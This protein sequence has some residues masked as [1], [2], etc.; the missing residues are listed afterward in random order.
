MDFML[1]RKNGHG[2]TQS[3]YRVTQSFLIAAKQLKRK[4]SYFTECY[5]FWKFSRINILTIN[6]LHN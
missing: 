6:Y 5:E 4:K 2:A 3:F 1:K